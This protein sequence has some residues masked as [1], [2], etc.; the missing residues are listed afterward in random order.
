MMNPEARF[1][2]NYSLQF[3][4]LGCIAVKGDP[5]ECENLVRE[6]CAKL[7]I[8]CEPIV[9][10]PTMATLEV[11]HRHQ[12]QNT[13][14]RE[15]NAD[16]P[17]FIRSFLAANGFQQMPQVLVLSG[18]NSVPSE[19]TYFLK[20]LLDERAREDDDCYNQLSA[21]ILMMAPDDAHGTY[22]ID[23]DIRGCICVI[24]KTVD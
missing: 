16:R 17:T 6:E 7:Q 13:V 1:Q 8:E 4:R 20:E 9:N 18:F 19:K 23:P 11:I 14:I 2:L 3:N 5:D 12:R 21:I 15:G 24:V 22:D 10:V